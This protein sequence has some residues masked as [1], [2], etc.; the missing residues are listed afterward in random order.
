MQKNLKFQKKIFFQKF[1]CNEKKCMKNRYCDSS[2]LRFRIDIGIVFK[3]RSTWKTSTRASTLLAPDARTAISQVTISK[4]T[5]CNSPYPV[6]V[7]S[8]KSRK[9]K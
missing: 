7:H 9:N 2:A 3:R 5:T 1:F 4:P 6:P 8:S